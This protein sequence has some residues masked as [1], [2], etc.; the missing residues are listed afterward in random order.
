MTHTGTSFISS[1]EPGHK[2]MWGG[3]GPKG[4]TH[5]LKVSQCP[6]P[7]L[8]GSH[9]YL[10]VDVHMQKLVQSSLKRMTTAQPQN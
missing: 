10:A 8:F 7:E 6:K 2:E 3:Q 9:K 4:I 1:G 5:T